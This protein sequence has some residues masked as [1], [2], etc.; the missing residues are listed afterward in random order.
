M[1]VTL[2]A[3]ALALALLL[4]GGGSSRISRVVIHDVGP[5]SQGAP[6]LKPWLLVMA[7]LTP[8]AIL[9]SAVRAVRKI[10]LDACARAVDREIGKRRKTGG[11][12][13]SQTDEEEHDDQGDDPGNGETWDHKT[14]DETGGD[15]VFA[16]LALAQEQVAPTPFVAALTAGGLARARSVP[17]APLFPPR[18]WRILGIATPISVGL[19]VV[20]L[21]VALAPETSQQDTSR[22]APARPN[23]SRDA[24]QS[25]DSK[26][27]RASGVRGPGPRVGRPDIHIDA[28]E[29]EGQRE[30]AARALESARVHGD[31]ALARAAGQMQQLAAGLSGPGLDPET[32]VTRLEELARRLEEPR[33]AQAGPPAPP[34]GSGA[35][36]GAS[37]GAGKVGGSAVAGSAAVGNGIASTTIPTQPAGADPE[38]RRRLEQNERDPNPDDDGAAA[39]HESSTA[40]AR[41][42]RRLERLQRELGP[43]QG[44]AERETGAER[45]LIANAARDLVE[46]IRRGGVD[47]RAS[48]SSDELR[49]FEQAAR[50]ANASGDPRVG[51][52]P[53]DRAKK[54]GGGDPAGG[55]PPSE[56]RENP[57]HADDYSQRASAA[58]RREPGSGGDAEIGA[59]APARGGRTVAGGIGSESGGSPL[60]ART[61]FGAASGHQIAAAVEQNSAGPSRAQ[62]I[63]T[64]AV[65]G[66]ATASYRRVFDD[67][68]VAV[69]ESLDLTEIPPGQRRLVRRYFQLIR[70]RDVE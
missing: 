36:A 15:W 58:G 4:G 30:Q 16:A 70:P 10:T 59:P 39:D 23:L 40:L 5:S 14:G 22:S 27:S 53:G 35:G 21:R 32:A 38:Q 50:G 43:E 44:D 17:P 9:G 34:S 18:R 52:E 54:A 20:A 31:P 46:R 33:G 45:Q 28:I 29:L 3:A 24:I 12:G 13:P 47:R 68:H 60:G 65:R 57:E 62:T 61:T 26:S 63:G 6:S 19:L 7:I 1:A 48:G 25:I 42:R 49:R 69:E 11:L 64:A 67:Y 37:A 66:F 41:P 55:P 51:R 2:V 8:A 56:L